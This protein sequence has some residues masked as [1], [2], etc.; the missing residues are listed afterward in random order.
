MTVPIGWRDGRWLNEPTTWFED[1]GD[2]LVSADEGSDFWR[3]TSYGFVH[4][5]GHA[6]LTGLP[7]GSAV[8]V[9]FT[10]DYDE[11]YDQAGLLVRADESHW[12]KAGV[13]ISDGHPQLGAVVTNGCSD[14]SMAPVPDWAGRRVTL[15]GSRAGDALTLRARVDDEPWRMFRVV[16]L[17][18]DLAAAAGPYCCAPQHA[19]L[20]VRFHT[21]TTGPADRALHDA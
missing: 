13:E 12:V 9:A 2:L 16:P 18:P 14:W 17:D 21:F 6:L 19:G 8:E 5:S 1:G 4:D 7:I 20:Q 3:T 10:L 11:M 15:R